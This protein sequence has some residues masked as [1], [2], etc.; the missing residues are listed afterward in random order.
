LLNGAEAGGW[1][2]GC[3]C[4]REK[5]GPEKKGV[6]ERTWHGDIGGLLGRV[7]GGLGD[8]SRGGGG[9]G[10]VEVPC[11]SNFRPTFD[12]KSASNV[13]VDVKIGSHKESEVR[14]SWGGGGSYC[15]ILLRA[16]KG[17]RTSLL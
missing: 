12:S 5:K 6:K 9:L 4:E 10:G 17:D 1:A 15:Q 11:E 7:G 2:R 14:P 8:D 13:R 16:Q 3:S